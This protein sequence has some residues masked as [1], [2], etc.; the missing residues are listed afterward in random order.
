M[1]KYE[2]FQRPGN[3][4][5]VECVELLGKTIKRMLSGNSMIPN[6]DFLLDKTVS[7]RLR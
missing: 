2:G 4:R 3:T 1:T 7:V 5:M 6:D